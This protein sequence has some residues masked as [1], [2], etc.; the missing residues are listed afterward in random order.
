M[1]Q[2]GG[3]VGLRQRKGASPGKRGQARELGMG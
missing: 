1:G 2:R 3:G